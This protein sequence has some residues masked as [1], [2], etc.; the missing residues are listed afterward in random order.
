MIVYPIKRDNIQPETTHSPNNARKLWILTIARLIVKVVNH[1]T[2]GMSTA[3]SRFLTLHETRDPTLPWQVRS[4]I[5]NDN[6]G[7]APPDYYIAG[8]SSKDAAIE[9]MEA[10]T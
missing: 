1:Y 9:Y 7:I 4:N 5:L 2:W 8:F 10:Q 3:V 6:S